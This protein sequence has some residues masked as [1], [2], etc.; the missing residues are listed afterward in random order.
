MK[1]KITS[2]VM[3]MI[4]LATTLTALQSVAV[5]SQQ[6]VQS[7]VAAKSTAA[8]QSSGLS[9]FFAPLIAMIEKDANE[10]EAEEAVKFRGVRGLTLRPIAVMS[11][12]P[13]K[14]ACGRQTE[15]GS[16]FAR[17]ATFSRSS[18]RAPSS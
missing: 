2:M 11:S 15:H 14:H 1:S 12:K 7:A 5:A 8:A 16:F 18:S 10:I 17:R 13:R 3:G 6:A 4:A 9:A